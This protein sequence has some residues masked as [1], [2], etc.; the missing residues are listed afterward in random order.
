MISGI[1]CFE[2]IVNN[3]KYIGQAI[4]IDRRIKLHLSCLKHSKDPCVLL[5]RAWD[6]HGESNFK[7]YTIEYC[8]TEQLNEKEISYIRNLNSHY[9][10]HGY[11]ISWGGSLF[12]KDIPMSEEIKL[13]ISKFKK[14]VSNIKLVGRK[15]TIETKKKM[16]ENHADVKG[17]KGSLY[18]KKGEDHPAFGRKRPQEERDFTPDRR[19]CAKVA[20]GFRV[21]GGD[22]RGRPRDLRHDA[23]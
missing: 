15:H 22:A 16:S 23:I 13:K 10:T 18:G 20:E 17:E 9:S 6:K 7:I 8:D 3:K 5:Q 14:G 2:N 19:G 1:Y 21:H 12:T 4:D 11:N